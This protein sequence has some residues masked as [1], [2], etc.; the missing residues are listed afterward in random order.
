MIFYNSYSQPIT[1]STTQYT[2]SQLV[3]QVL[4]NSP[5]VSG[6][7]VNFRTGTSYGSS[8][9]IGYFTNINSSFPYSNGVVLSTGDVTIIPG[10]NTSILSDGSTAYG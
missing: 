4:M 8:N 7:N 3:N 9:G 1:V 6:T 5:C 10:P 2:I